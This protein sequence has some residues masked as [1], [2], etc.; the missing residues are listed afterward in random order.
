MPRPVTLMMT[1]IRSPHAGPQAGGPPPSVGLRPREAAATIIKMITDQ[2]DHDD[3]DDDVGYAN[4]PAGARAGSHQ[5][6]RMKLWLAAGP[7]AA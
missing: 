7:E 2:C 5:R 3:R 1:R 4:G 6:S